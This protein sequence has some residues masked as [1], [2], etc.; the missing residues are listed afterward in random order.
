M[1]KDNMIVPEG[2]MDFK[3]IDADVEAIEA[4]IEAGKHV[5]MVYDNGCAIA[6][7]DDRQIE[8]CG[9]DLVYAFAYLLGVDEFMGA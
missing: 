2:A 4:A 1:D 6:V 3:S 5:L 7:F 9:N 8:I